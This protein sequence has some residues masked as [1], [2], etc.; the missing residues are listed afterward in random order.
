VSST[1]N[2]LYTSPTIQNELLQTAVNL[3]HKDTVSHV[4][5]VSSFLI[6]CDKTMERGK[7]GLMIITIR[8]VVVDC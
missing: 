3:I 5:E 2:A 6:I 4:R 7:R 1:E 8:H